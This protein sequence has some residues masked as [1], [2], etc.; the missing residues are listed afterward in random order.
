MHVLLLAGLFLTLIVG[1]AHA[2]TTDADTRSSAR[3]IEITVFKS[4]L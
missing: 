4:P 3:T 2:Q 1:S